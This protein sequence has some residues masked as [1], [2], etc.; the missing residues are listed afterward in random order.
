MKAGINA[1][2]TEVN[3]CWNKLQ[4]AMKE[5]EDGAFEGGRQILDMARVFDVLAHLFTPMYSLLLNTPLLLYNNCYSQFHSASPTPSIVLIDET[6]PIVKQN[7][8]SKCI[9]QNV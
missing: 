7:A 2:G 8:N 3:S 1:M 4:D 6:S 9:H 5:L